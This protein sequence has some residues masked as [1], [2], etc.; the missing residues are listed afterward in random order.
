MSTSLSHGSIDTVFDSQVVKLLSDAKTR[1]ESSAH[2]TGSGT[3]QPFGLI[4]RLELTTASRVSGASN[5]A[6][7]SS[8][9]YNVDSALPYRYR[10][11]RT[12]VANPSVY[13]AVR[14]LANG[15][16]PQNSSFWA[17]LGD[18]QPERLLGRPIYEASA[19]ETASSFTTASSDDCLVLGD[20][21]NYLIVDRIGTQ[22]LFNP[23]VLGSNR[24]PSLQV[25]WTLWWRTGCDVTNVDAFRLLRL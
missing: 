25:S 13:N 19:M 14:Q 6:I 11:N 24:R 21:A 18:N 12:W 16:V 7:T 15:T 9:L 2:W 8:D 10:P 20:F 1:L 5:V 3:S 23:I 4:T 17:T 22:I